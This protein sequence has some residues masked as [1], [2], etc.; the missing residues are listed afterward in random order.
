MFE[1]ASKRSQDLGALFRLEGR[2]SLEY[3]YDS[4]FSVLGKLEVS[5]NSAICEANSELIFIPGENDA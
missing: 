2:D 1:Y 3:L 4:S 5:E